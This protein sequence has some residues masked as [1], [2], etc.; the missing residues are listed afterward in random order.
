[1][2]T[3]DWPRYR[4]HKVVKALEIET[5]MPRISGGIAVTAGG[6]DFDLPTV[7]FSRYSPVKG[8]FLVEYEDGYQSFSPRAAFLAGYTKVEDLP[9]LPDFNDGD[10]TQAALGHPARS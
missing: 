2:D 1:M 4:S 8:D 9:D 3:Q 10:D 7:M 5:V 6:R